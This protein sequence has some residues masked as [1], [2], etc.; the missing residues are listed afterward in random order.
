MQ[1]RTYRGATK[2]AYRIAIPT[3]R[4]LIEMSEQVQTAA[5]M[6]GGLVLENEQDLRPDNPFEQSLI[7]QIKAEG[8]AVWKIEV[9]FNEIEG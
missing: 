1:V 3:P 2:S 8:A 9:R 4:D 5:R 7:L 6:L